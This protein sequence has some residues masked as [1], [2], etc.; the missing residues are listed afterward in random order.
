MIGNEISVFYGGDHC[1]TIVDE[2]KQH[3]EMH[4]IL[5]K[6]LC[7]LL[8]KVGLY[9]RDI[10]TLNDFNK[11]WMKST[12]CHEDFH[13][14]CCKRVKKRIIHDKYYSVLD[15]T[16]GRIEL[17]KNILSELDKLFSCVDIK[18]TTINTEADFIYAWCKSFKYHRYFH[19]DVAKN[20]PDPD[21]RKALMA[22]WEGDHLTFLEY[23]VK[24]QK[25][26]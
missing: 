16:R 5:L 11:M 18:I 24:C 6:E 22:L 20:N 26:K 10:K 13:K 23:S 17:R 12:P 7:W 9:Y 25:K 1:Y 4:R 2:D 21:E 3:I 8:N 14:L 19:Y 15:I